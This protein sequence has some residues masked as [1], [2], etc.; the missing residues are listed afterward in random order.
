MR[1]LFLG[2]VECGKWYWSCVDFYVVCFVP[3]C[4]SG[5]VP[6]CCSVWS[7]P[8]CC[9]GWS[10]PACCSPLFSSFVGHQMRSATCA[11]IMESS[12]FLLLSLFIALVSVSA[13]QPTLTTRSNVR[14]RTNT[15]SAWFR[16]SAA[17]SGTAGGEGAH[18]IPCHLRYSLQQCLPTSTTKPFDNSIRHHIMLTQ[19]TQ[20]HS[21]VCCLFLQYYFHHS[22]LPSVTERCFHTTWPI[23]IFPSYHPPC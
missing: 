1:F 12:L 6:A 14:A 5:W 3:A 17:T 19:C 23:F 4:C 16:V 9:S 21:I 2:W 10:V 18:N 13:L 11:N 8:A 20:I 15:P 22:V 7:V